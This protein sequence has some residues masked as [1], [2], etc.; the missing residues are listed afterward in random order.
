MLLSVRCDQIEPVRTLGHG[1]APS[2]LPSPHGVSR[3]RFSLG[4]SSRQSPWFLFLGSVE[5]KSQAL[6]T[7]AES[8]LA[9]V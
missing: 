5:S 2:G 8:Q 7:G 1:S 9:A 3:G 4:C 6:V